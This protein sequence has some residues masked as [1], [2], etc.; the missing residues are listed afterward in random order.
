MAQPVT[1]VALGDSLTA[2]Y[3]LN[4]GEGLVAQLQAWLDAEGAEISVQN[5]GVSGDT[6]AGGLSRLDWALGPDADALMVILG[7]NDMMRG[8]A[9]SEV[10]ANLEAIMAG[11]KTRDLPVLVVAMKAP[12]NWGPQYKAEFDAI[13]PALGADVFLDDFFTGLLALGADPQD[14]A[15]LAKW[16]QGDGIHPNAEGVKELVKAIGPKVIELSQK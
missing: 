1:L 7:G 12:G 3:G 9:P 10:E 6:T 14:P 13:Y 16:M 8:I 5:A 11:A 2:G 4:E 15:S